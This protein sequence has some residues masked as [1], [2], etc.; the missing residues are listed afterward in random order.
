MKAFISLDDM[1]GIKAE[2]GDLFSDIKSSHRTEALARGF[3]FK[4]NAALRASLKAGSKECLIDNLA[5]NNYLGDHGFTLARDNGLTEGVRRQQ[6]S[7]ALAA[8]KEVM[9]REA[10]LSH[11]GFGVFHGRSKSIERQQTEFLENR[12]SM[13]EPYAVEEFIHACAFLS[14]FEKRA[15]I[16]KVSSSYGLKHEAERFFEGQVDNSYISNGMFI[17]A[18]IHL[19]F[20]VQRR[21]PNA[22]LNISLRERSGT[23]LAKR[24]PAGHVGGKVRIQAWRNMMVAAVN[25][26]LDQGI[27]GL[28]PDDNRWDGDNRTYRFSFVNAA[29]IANVRDAGFGELSIKVAVRPTDEAERWIQSTNAGLL[30]GDAFA[31]GWFERTNGTWL[32]SSKNPCNAFRREIMPVI[33]T[34]ILTPNGY[35]DEGRFML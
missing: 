25:A 33:A 32:Q 23:K 4:T 28:A 26:G 1:D 3:G 29:A 30:A 9:V 31:S 22:Y 13:T 15:T 27:F 2:L 21:G 11:L 35:K 19:G 24:R 16:N 20:R 10:H 34:A 6:F 5:F 18:A 12:R 14:R 8:I 7:V 17:A